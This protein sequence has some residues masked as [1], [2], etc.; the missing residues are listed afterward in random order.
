MEGSMPIPQEDINTNWI[1]VSSNETV[2]QVQAKLQADRRARAYQYIVFATRDGNYIVAR[3]LEIEQLAAASGQD[4]RGTPIGMLKGLPKPVIGIEQNSMGISSAREERDAQPGKRLVVLSNGQPIGLLTNEKLSGDAL[5]PDPFATVPRG[6][7]V[8]GIEDGPAVPKAPVPLPPAAAANTAPAPGPPV[9]TRVIN[10]WFEGVEP[11]TPLQV[12]RPYELKFNVEQKRADALAAVGGIGPELQRLAALGQEIVTILVVLDPG[13]FTLYG[14]D[15]LEIVVPTALNEPSK[16]TVAFTIEAKKE[17]T[18]KLN[19]IFY[20]NGKL[21]QKVEWIIQVGG[22]VAAGEKALR[23][24]ATGLTMASAMVQQIRTHG[25]PVNVMILAKEAGYQVI[26]QGG[27]VA[28]AFLKISAE[29]IAGWLKY[30][31]GVLHDIVYLQDASG[32]NIYQAE[33]TTIAPDVHTATLKKLAEAGLY[34]FD[35][36]FYGNSGPDARAMGDLLKEL[37][38]KHQL[39]VQIVAERFFFPWSLLYDGDDSDNPDPKAFWG[40]KHVIEYM[41][42]FSSPTLVSFAPVIEIGDTLDIAFVCNNTIDTQFGPVVQG[43]RDAFNAL[44]GVSVKDYA[45][46]QDFINLMKDPNAPPLIYF[47]C[48]AVSKFPGEEGG[49]DDSKIALTDAKIALRDLKIK[50]RTSLPPLLNAPLVF[51]NACESAELSPYLYDGLMP[52]MIA[53]GVRGMIGTEVET[54]ALFAAEFAK[55]FIRRFA[56]GGQPLGE[57]LLDMRR[58]YL[59]QKNNVMGLVYALY[60]SGDVVVERPS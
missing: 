5:P 29:E 38:R 11:N 22:R 34:L 21:F 23:A 50:V 16:N 55:D 44:P 3:W 37:S 51:L 57:L 42:E 17:G 24:A 28:R 12:R 40:F 19:A 2:G 8:L 43:Q 9:D 31:R 18:N 32:N 7:A 49:V 10:T 46:T 52:F 15:S 59:E 41:P 58:E 30:A 54:P 4:I 20:V 26:V 36:L 1:W 25:Q 14:V 53:R 47:Y 33:N 39:Q 45:N 27:G 60:S 35:E 48:H 6:A 13:D 56:A